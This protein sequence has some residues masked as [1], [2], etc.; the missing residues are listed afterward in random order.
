MPYLRGSEGDLFSANWGELP[1]AA[2]ESEALM[3]KSSSSEVS[4]RG[5]ELVAELNSAGAAL[6]Q[7]Q[8]A[9]MDA[10]ERGVH[11]KAARP[12]LRK[13][14]E[15][16][17]SA[18]RLLK[19]LD[20]G[21]E[22]DVLLA[23]YYISRGMIVL[24]L[25]I[26]EREMKERSPVHLNRAID[27][28]LKSAK[29]NPDAKTY[30]RL[31]EAYALAGDL[32]AAIESLEKATRLDF[33]C[34]EAYL[35]KGLIHQERGEAE[36]AHEGIYYAIAINPDLYREEFEQIM[37]AERESEAIWDELLSRPEAQEM[38]QEWAEEAREAYRAGKTTPIVF[39]DE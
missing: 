37:Q 18:I 8:A 29:L 14:A 28:F 30:L 38:L 15:R 5:A 16:Y 20:F 25:N 10:V 36:D 27:D 17:A 11:P 13:A 6:E 23:S 1:A 3:Q 19:R 2:L 31:G 22:A 26:I 32:D 9:H 34:A 12:P 33:D 24:T 4:D 39:E 35:L 21:K 7:A